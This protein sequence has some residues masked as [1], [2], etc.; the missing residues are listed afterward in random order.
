MKRNNVPRRKWARRGARLGAIIGVVVA[1]ISL[2]LYFGV[3]N[4]VF[5]RELDEIVEL[6]EKNMREEREWVDGQ[7]AWIKIDGTNIDYPVMQASNNVWYLNHDYLGREEVTGAIFLDYRNS[8]DF[9]DDVSVI[10]GHRTNGHLM[11]SDVARYESGEY[12]SGHLQGELYLRDGRIMRLVAH[13][14]RLLSGDD[15]LYRDFSWNDS[16]VIILS[17]CSREMRGSRDV[18]VM[19][20]M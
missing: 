9:S 20:K 5:E 17:T 1:A 2:W 19:K 4:G 7:V 12:F 10:Y 6:R 14:Y 11:F 3:E 13:R 15:G 8:S 16:G 18:L